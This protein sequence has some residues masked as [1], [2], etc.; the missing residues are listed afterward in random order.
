MF[1]VESGTAVIVPLPVTPRCRSLWELVGRSSVLSP[2]LRLASGRV[3]G[4]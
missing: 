4:G 2:E 3:A 1:R